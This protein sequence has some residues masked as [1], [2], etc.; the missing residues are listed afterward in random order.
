[1]KNE[2]RELFEGAV[3]TTIIGSVLSIFGSLFQKED[4]VIE[5]HMVEVTG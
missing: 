4:A 3:Y 5:R 1:M 2:E